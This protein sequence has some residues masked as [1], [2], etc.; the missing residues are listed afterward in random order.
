MIKQVQSRLQ[1]RK[2]EIELKPAAKEWLA[3]EGYDPV[4]G[5]RPLRRTIQREIE[6]PISSRI[7]AGEFKEG[8]RVTIDIEDGKLHIF[9]AG[10]EALA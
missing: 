8:D 3:K 4:Y 1:E 2:I 5:A 6:N 10:A 7:L 9:K